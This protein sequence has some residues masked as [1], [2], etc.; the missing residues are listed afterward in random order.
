MTN[1]GINNRSQS[2]TT[3]TF[4]N[5]GTTVTAG[6]GVI[7]TTGGVTSSAG[8][9]TVVAGTTAINDTGNVTTSIGGTTSTGP[10]NIGTSTGNQTIHIGFGVANKTIVLGVANGTTSVDIESGSGGAQLN[11]VGGTVAVTGSAGATLDSAAGTIGVGAG[12]T[13]NAVNIGTLAT[14]GRIITI[15]NVTGTTAVNVNTGSAGT[16]YTTTNGIFTLAT[17]TG[18]ITISGD[19][20]ATTLNI[21]TGAAVVKTISIGGTG[22]NVIAIA[23]TQTAGSVA[24]GAAMTTGT[25]TIGGT[26]LQTGTITFGGGTGAQT[27]NI[28]TGGTG[29]KTIHIGDSAVANVITVGSTTG[30]AS[31]TLQSGSGNIAMN[32]GLT[33]D[34]T[35]RMTNSVQPAFCAQLS[36]NQNNV[37]GDFTSYTV[38]FDT[39]RFDQNSNYNGATGIFTAPKTGRYFFVTNIGFNGLTVSFTDVR[40]AFVGSV[41]GTIN[42][43]RDNGGA[44]T[45]G[46]NIQAA[47]STIIP[48]TANDTFKV[49][50][51]VGNST[52][53]V[54]VNGG[55]MNTSFAGYL[56]C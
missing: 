50:V 2:L 14:A 21:G 52:K 27:V 44:F 38:I 56:I 10:I 53:T 31:L 13:D 23:N 3:T 33:V 48:M 37:T 41:E 7:A 1:N 19:A 39:V 47:I 36:A 15:G 35:G 29:V 43:Y 42:Y 32:A 18:A 40:V 5:A 34:S 28:G 9:L 8:G 11:S 26:G 6:T 55:S 54:G 30:A 24:I 46:G 4:V 51:Q 45:V 20:S 16:T 17:G 12:N 22:A 49:V 25:I